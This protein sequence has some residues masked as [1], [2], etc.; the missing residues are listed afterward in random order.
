MDL[1]LIILIILLLFGAASVTADTGTE[2]A[3]GS[4]GFCCWFCCCT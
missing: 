3:W 4:A 2:A 1:I